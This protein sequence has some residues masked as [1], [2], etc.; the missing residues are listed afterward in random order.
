MA[1]GVLSR[2]V[3][4]GKDV[5]GHVAVMPFSYVGPTSYAT[6]GEAQ[7]ASAFKLG[8]VEYCPAF[9]GVNSG[10][11]AAIVYQYNIGTSKMQ[12]FWQNELVASGLVEVTAG[13]DLSGY[14]GRGMAYGKG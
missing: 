13:T 2:T 6:G 12:A 3:S 8:V 14:T 5:W 4:R 7:A 9:L 11:T 1:A 10:G